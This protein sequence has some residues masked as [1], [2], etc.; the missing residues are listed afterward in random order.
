MLVSFEG[1]MTYTPCATAQH[2]REKRNIEAISWTT[3]AGPRCI[4]QI[5]S[6]LVNNNQRTPRAL[7]SVQPYTDRSDRR[8]LGRQKPDLRSAIYRTNTTQTVPRH[9]H[10]HPPP[11]SHPATLKADGGD[12]ASGQEHRLPVW[13]GWTWRRW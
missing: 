6:S 2:R 13:N 1:T 7:L 3:V 5:D 10:R 4:R 8:R 9:R 11:P 12:L